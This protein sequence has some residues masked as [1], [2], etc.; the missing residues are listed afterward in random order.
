MSRPINPQSLYTDERGLTGSEV[1]AIEYAAGLAALGHSVTFYSN[2]GDPCIARSVVY[3]HDRQWPHNHADGWDAVISFMNAAP[4]MMVEPGP[5]RMFNM[6]C[7]DFGGQPV[8]WEQ[9][10]DLLCALSHDHARRLSRE[11]AFPTSNIRVMPNGVDLEAFRPGSV[12]VPGRCLWA[13]SHDRGLHHVLELWPEVRA[14]VPHAELHVFYDLEGIRKFAGMG[15]TDV[16]FLLELQQRSIYEVE[17]MKRLRGHGVV[18][19][20]PV[21]RETMQRE[22]G[23][24]EC[25]PYATNPVRY[26]ETFGCTVLEA[27]A[28]GCVPVLCFEDSFSELWENRGCPGVPRPFESHR[29]AYVAKLIGML[30]NP[31]QYIG[32][33]DKAHDFAWDPLVRRLADC[34]Q[35]RGNGGLAKMLE[36][37]SGE[38]GSGES[39][40]GATAA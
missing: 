34:I 17:M 29:D 38:L 33:R 36:P 35:G 19:R 3:K 27:M 30:K 32:L 1:S 2:V 5:L 8:G 11:T 9:R 18:L 23:V 37:V 26:T 15:A 10:V 16:P 7:G 40:L 20:G 31:G 13:S 21:S 4:L 25:L 39:A 22:M 28:A 14:A 12:K 24:A 6:Q